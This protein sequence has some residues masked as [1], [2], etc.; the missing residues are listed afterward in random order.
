MARRPES[1]FLCAA[2]YGWLDGRLLET[3]GYAHWRWQ[4]QH[5][6]RHMPENADMEIWGRSCLDPWHDHPAWLPVMGGCSPD[7]WLAAGYDVD[8]L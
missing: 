5:G 4:G 6:T 1:R 7:V 3:A 2:G 8:S